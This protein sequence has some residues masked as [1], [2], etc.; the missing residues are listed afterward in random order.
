VEA[1]MAGV[2]G[3]LIAGGVFLLLRA[4]TFPII[5]GLLLLGYATNLFLLATGRLGAAAP[6]IITP[7]STQHA[8]PLPQALILTS[9]V[10][11]FGMVAFVV[12]L[13][14]RNAIAAD[15]GETS[16]AGKTHDGASGDERLERS[17]PT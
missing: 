12:V 4:R 6:P 17:G 15:A 14:L 16:I 1:L 11:S 8:D 5:L 3:V 7:G 2:I 9:I 10:I 13:A